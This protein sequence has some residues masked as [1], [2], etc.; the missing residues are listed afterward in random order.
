MARRIHRSHMITVLLA[1]L[2]AS[3]VAQSPA[4]ETTTREPITDSS[5]SLA[6]PRVVNTAVVSMAV[7]P[8]RGDYSNPLAAVRNAFAGDRWCIPQRTPGRPCVLFIREGI[9]SLNATLTIPDGIAVVGGGRNRTQLRARPGVAIAVNFFGGGAASVSDLTIENHQ[10]SAPEATGLL[11]HGGLAER[12]DVRADSALL[13]VGCMG[14]SGTGD[15]SF[16]EVSCTAVG[17]QHSI[18]LR[19]R[20]AIITTVTRSRMVAFGASDGNVGVTAE[21]TDTDTTL[22]DT[23]V[24]VGGPG[25]SVGVIGHQEGSTRIFDGEIRAGDFGVIGAFVDGRLEMRGTRVVTQ[26]TGVSWSSRSTCELDRVDIFAAMV[27]VE[28]TTELSVPL[29]RTKIR[30][31]LLRGG[32]RA[33]SITAQG[34]D[35]ITIDQ[36]VL[37]SRNVLIGVTSGTPTVRI[38][39]TK[40]LGPLLEG[41]ATLVCAGVYDASYQFLVDTCPG[42]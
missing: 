5:K 1:F 2:A 4:A 17:G 8:T 29:C 33:I 26:G 6:P 22:I 31:A 25:Q 42:M 14:A 27:A 19:L 28:L 37:E 38:G 41:T 21:F 13:N 20:G 39:A 30:D 9:Y 16:I 11:T 35:E 23:A 24:T 7:G 34:T 18:A 40:L 10:T 36:S 3:G 15:I 32:E 12:V